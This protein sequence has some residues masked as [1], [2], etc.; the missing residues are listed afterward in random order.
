MNGSLLLAALGYPLFE[1]LTEQTES[2]TEQAFVCNRS[3]VKAS[4]IYT[5]EGM[6]VLNGSSAPMTTERKT[7]QR[8]FDKRDELLA[9]GIIAIEADRFVFQRDS[10][11]QT[12]QWGFNIFITSH[13]KW[14]E[15][16]ENRGRCYLA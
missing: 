8:F 12:P 2:K 3:G 11:F 5:N 1:P 10:L 6:V 9:K 15:R 14:L 7:K 16:L 13:V 4:G